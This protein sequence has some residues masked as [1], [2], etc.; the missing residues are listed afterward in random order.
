MYNE[1]LTRSV[2]AKTWGYI[3]RSTRVMITQSMAVPTTISLKVEE[4]GLMEQDML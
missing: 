1:A 4:L 2:K 3:I